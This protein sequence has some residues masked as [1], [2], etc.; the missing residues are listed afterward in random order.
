MT[1]QMKID[2]AEITET[3][4]D[5][6]NPQGFVILHGSLAREGCVMTGAGFGRDPFEAKARVFAT[7]AGA[8][9]A[10]TDG[11]VAS[12]EAIIIA[13]ADEAEM[14]AI[15]AALSSAELKDIALISNGKFAPSTNG[16]TIS[17]VGKSIRYVQNADTIT[18]DIKG[19]R[20]NIDADLTIRSGEAPAA[21]VNGGK[22]KNGFAPLAKYAAMLDSASQAADTAA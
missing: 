7:E 5:A 3:P 6:E 20:L 22:V 15:F 13:A 16:I 1:A 17:H 9:A 4:A 19:R 21:T 11:R 10:I 2:I 18:I 12:G 8:I 14:S